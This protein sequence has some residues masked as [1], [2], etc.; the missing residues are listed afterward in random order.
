MHF[1]SIE[2]NNFELDSGEKGVTKWIDEIVW[3]EFYKNIMF[4][5]PRVSKDK[6]FQD[7]TNKIKWRFNE[8]DLKHG[9]MVI[10][11]FL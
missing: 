9:R 6:P 3:R 2:K 5:F 8:K 11:D 4:S 10:L 7:Y 1:R